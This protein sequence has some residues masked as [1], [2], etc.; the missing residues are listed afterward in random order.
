MFLFSSLG[1]IMLT[2]GAARLVGRWQG[3]QVKAKRLRVLEGVA[4]GKDRSL[5]LV[6]VGKEVMVVGTSQA[7]IG[8]VHQVTDPEAAA[9]LLAEP[10][11][12]DQTDTP[13]VAPSEVAVRQ[14]LEQIRSLLTRAGR[15]FDV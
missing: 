3:M 7:G 2:Y 14:S 6:A 4:V 5:L 15:R 13:G 12:S 10:S 9:A 8:L 11:G 1:V